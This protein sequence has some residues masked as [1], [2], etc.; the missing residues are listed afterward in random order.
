MIKKMLR[1]EILEIYKNPNN[2]GRK[3]SISTIQGICRDFSR[4]E[5]ID[6][7]KQ[8][9]EEGILESY[10]AKSKIGLPLIYYRRK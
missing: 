4:T 5:I 2:R 1:K 8:L 7:V 10:M 3:I 9:E 6:V